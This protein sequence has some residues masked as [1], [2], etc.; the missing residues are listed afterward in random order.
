[1]SCATPWRAAVVLGGEGTSSDVDSEEEAFVEERGSDLDRL[2][3]I[4]V[5]SGEPIAVARQRVVDAFE[6]RYLERILAVHQGNVTHAAASAG[7]AR[8]HL[9]RLR[10]RR[11]A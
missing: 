10:A 5:R 9:Q 3:D 4:A 1:M 11:R 6:E 8:R 2:A 7:V